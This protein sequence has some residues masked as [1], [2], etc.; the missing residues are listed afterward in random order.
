VPTAARSIWTIFAK[1]VVHVIAGDRNRGG[2]TPPPAGISVTTVV[3]TRDRK[4]RPSGSDCVAAE[5]TTWDAFAILMGE[6][7]DAL[8]GFQ[9]LADQ[10]G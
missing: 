5:P 8:A 2:T 7:S 9:A 4:V 3:L 10:N 6:P 1:R